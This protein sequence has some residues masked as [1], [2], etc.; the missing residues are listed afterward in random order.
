MEIQIKT[1][2]RF[3]LS[4]LRMTTIKKANAKEKAGERK[5]SPEEMQ[6]EA[7]STEIG[8]KLLKLKRRTFVVNLC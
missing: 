2:L 6:I 4:P 7:H 3:Y 1:L 8:I 5:P